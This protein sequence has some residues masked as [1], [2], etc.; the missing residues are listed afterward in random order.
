MSLPSLL[1]AVESLPLK[2]AFLRAIEHPWSRVF[3]KVFSTFD[4]NTVV[5]CQFYTGFLPVEHL[6]RIK[7]FKFIDSLKSN[8]NWLMREVYRLC[9]LDELRAITEAYNVNIDHICNKH[10]IANWFRT[11]IINT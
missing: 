11:S 9:A 5:M 1:Y 7:K 4:A 6:V 3:M 2:N 8:S 10:Y